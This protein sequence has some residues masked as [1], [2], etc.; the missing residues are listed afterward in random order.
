MTASL[1][2]SGSVTYNGYSTE[3]FVVQRTAAYVDQQD[4]HIAE[5]TVMGACFQLHGFSV[6]HRGQVA[7]CGDASS[8][9]EV[10][11]LVT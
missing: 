4:N 1:Q 2:M 3:E 9:D 10:L 11:T 8:N 7:T 5:L 6:H